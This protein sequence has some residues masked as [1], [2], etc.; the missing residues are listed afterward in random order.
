MQSLEL[1]IAICQADPVFQGILEHQEQKDPENAYHK[2]L[3][4]QDEDTCYVY[5]ARASVHMDLVKKF[6]LWDT[7]KTKQ[8]RIH[9]ITTSQHSTHTY[10]PQN[11]EMLDNDK[12]LQKVQSSPVKILGGGSVY[13]DD[14][15]TLVIGDYSGH[16]GAVPLH[17]A[18]RIATALEPYLRQAGFMFEKSRAHPTECYIKEENWKKN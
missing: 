1:T 3:I 16:F 11:K 2:F 18:K 7:Y 4:T 5:M 13:V 15:N 12:A 14:N 6:E 10:V 17:V 9:S 8:E